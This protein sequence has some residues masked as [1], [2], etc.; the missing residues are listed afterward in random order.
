MDGRAALAVVVLLA[1]G[2][3]AVATPGVL[4]GGLLD[5]T[6]LDGTP[7]DGIA[8]DLTGSS[9]DAGGDHRTAV[10]VVP[11][12]GATSGSIRAGSKRTYEIVVA[13]PGKGVGSSALSLSVANGS[14]A[15]VVSAAVSGDPDVT[16]VSPVGDGADR[17][18]IRTAAAD[19]EGGRDTVIAT[20]TVRGE[21]DGT[22]DLALRVQSLGSPAGDAYAVT[23]SPDATLAVTGGSDDES[24]EPT[25]EDDTTAG[26]TTPGGDTTTSD[27]TTQD[28]TTADP[29]QPPTVEV[30]LDAR[31][32]ENG[33]YAGPVTVDLAASD[34]D[35]AV[36]TV[37][38]SVDGG[39]FETLDPDR[40]EVTVQG[41]GSHEV[42]YR[43]TDDDG[44]RKTD[45][46][47]FEIA[48]GGSPIESFT[49]TDPGTD[50]GV[51]IVTDEALAGV[52]VAVS[53]DGEVL[54]TFDE[55]QLETGDGSDGFEYAA[56][57]RQAEAGT[58]YTVTIEELVTYRDWADG[59]RRSVEVT[60]DRVAMNLT[61]DERTVTE[62]DAV[63]FRV[64]RESDGFGVENATVEIDGN[65]VDAGFDGTAA[66]EFTEPGNYTATARKS[67]DDG[68]RYVADSVEITVR[69]ETGG[70]DPASTWPGLQGEQSR[71]GYRPD[72]TVLRGE[73]ERDWSR[74]AQSYGSSP[75]MAGGALYTASGE[76]VRAHAPDPGN[77]TWH[78]SLD[79]PIEV[80]PVAGQ[81]RSGERVLYVADSEGTFHALDAD[82]G[83][84]R[85]SKQLTAPGQST[86]T[87]K[88]AFAVLD[89]VAYV[90][91]DDPFAEREDSQHDD[92]LVALDLRTQSVLWTR[93]AG[94]VG[95]VAVHDE[96]LYVSAGEDRMLMK[97]EPGAEKAQYWSYRTPTSNGLARGEKTLGVPSVRGDTAYVRSET[98]VVH[99]VAVDGG[100]QRWTSQPLPNDRPANDIE[101]PSSMAIT[102]DLVIVSTDTATLYALDRATGERVW[103]AT[104]DD[105][106]GSPVVVDGTAYV[107]S[108]AG[109][110]YA[111]DAA[112]GS[113]LWS[114]EADRDGFGRTS[115]VVVDGRVYYAGGLS[116][117]AVE[118]VAS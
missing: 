67:A 13:D 91:V 59:Q 84:R 32:F 22:T 81:D 111:L 72:G 51:S 35:G 117:Y 30:T 93:E 24:G 3:M 46:V 74:F 29:N 26:S 20:V 64:T 19:L 102:D 54:Q 17:V 43:V 89:G 52:E 60:R 77:I 18:E 101:H 65:A 34:A 21:R 8:G 71:S 47:P 97:F 92:S 37:A 90:P 57:Y 5:G 78:A 44:A 108:D 103:N 116:V 107:V 11:A 15:D 61:A 36:E 66:Y 94:H 82:T 45:T 100:E 39:E 63:T 56:T 68:N 104:A 99:A 10:S 50:V 106:L 105:Q 2:G 95:G 76:V 23:G 110:L 25:T 14:V 7:F 115:P 4:D 112:D 6:P 49:A 75:V 55:S 27:E 42:T 58:N 1:V 28:E 9:D 98:G 79:A 53:A 83:E 96:K 48:V 40:P 38:V 85:W 73:V 86:A 87:V 70:T 12:D 62:G 16:D 31:Q 69:A 118:P 113:T 80:A 109:T 114:H 88:E 33:S 41:R